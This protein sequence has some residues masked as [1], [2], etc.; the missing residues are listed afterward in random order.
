LGN[1]HRFCYQRCVPRRFSSVPGLVL[2][3]LP[4]HRQ[5]DW[6]RSVLLNTNVAS[7]LKFDLGWL[8]R[9]DIGLMTKIWRAT[10]VCL[11]VSQFVI[12]L[13]VVAVLETALVLGFLKLNPYVSAFPFSRYQEA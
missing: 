4:L 2:G 1:E 9:E 10:K 8:V 11:G 12:A 13:A 7:V 3:D 5:W 6:D